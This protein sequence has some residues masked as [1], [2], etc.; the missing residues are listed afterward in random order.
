MQFFE[1]VLTILQLFEFFWPFNLMQK[2]VM[3]TNRS[4]TKKI[5]AAENIWSRAKCENLIVAR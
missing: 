5:D 4:A 1:Y 3:E 2:I